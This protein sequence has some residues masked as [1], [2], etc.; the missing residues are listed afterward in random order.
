MPISER[1]DCARQP[2]AKC[3]SAISRSASSAVDPTVRS[4]PMQTRAIAGNAILQVEAAAS[5]C[6]SPT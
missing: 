3:I 2:R 1:S 5:F 4:R 6:L